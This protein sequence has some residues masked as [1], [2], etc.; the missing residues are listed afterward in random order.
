MSFTSPWDVRWEIKSLLEKDRL[1]GKKG[2][3]HVNRFK[4]Q[5]PL[6][7]SPPTAYLLQKRGASH[8]GVLAPLSV[9]PKTQARPPLEQTETRNCGHKSGRANGGYGRA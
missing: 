9:V 1:L 6:L 5:Y 7:F 3:D 2:T 8:E 4:E